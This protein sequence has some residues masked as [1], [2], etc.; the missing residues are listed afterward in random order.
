MYD[1]FVIK[2]AL[3]SIIMVGVKIL[4]ERRQIKLSIIIF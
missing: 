2:I 4:L 3:W 1:K